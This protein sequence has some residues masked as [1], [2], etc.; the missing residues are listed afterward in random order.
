MSINECLKISRT[1][2][3]FEAF[4]GLL[5][6]HKLYALAMSSYIF[7]TWGKQKRV[8]LLLQELYNEC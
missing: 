3:E 8:L 7:N 2:E 4:S 1:V 5:I 6:C